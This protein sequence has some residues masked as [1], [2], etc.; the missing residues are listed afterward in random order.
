MTRDLDKDLSDLLTDKLTSET[1]MR[2]SAHHRMSPPNLSTAASAQGEAE[3][4]KDV[5]AD[6]EADR[7]ESLRN[8]RFQ[9]LSAFKKRAKQEAQWREAVSAARRAQ[10]LGSPSRRCPSLATPMFYFPSPWGERTS[11]TSPSSTYRP[12]CLEAGTRIA[13]LWR[14]A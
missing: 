4:Q 9:T 13:T 6:L 5:E 7:M 11:W 2:V 14:L 8:P 12:P 1:T 10:S 3:T